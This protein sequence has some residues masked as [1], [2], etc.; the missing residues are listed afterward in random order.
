MPSQIVMP[1]RGA[2]PCPVDIS[3]AATVLYCKVVGV[4]ADVACHVAAGPVVLRWAVSNA[5]VE[6]TLVSI[7]TVFIKQ[8]FRTIDRRA[9][10]GRF[11]INLDYNQ[12][13]GST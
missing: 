1:Y 8:L 3:S 5:A 6:S 10:V 11:A 12:I 2:L 13:M 9:K 7:P 4:W